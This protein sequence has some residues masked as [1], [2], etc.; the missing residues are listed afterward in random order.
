M[1]HL[2]GGQQGGG[3]WGFV[4]GGM[5]GISAA[6]ARS[7]ARFGMQIATQAPVAEVLVSAGRAQDVR[8]VDGREFRAGVVACNAAATT[9]FR[10]LVARRHLPAEL[11]R[12]IDTFRTFSTVFKM[13]IAAHEPP[14]Y[15]AFDAAREQFG[16]PTYVHIR[17]DL[18]YLERAH[19]DAKY[20]WYPR[21]PIPT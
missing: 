21:R 6:I 16:Y 17:P 13:N 7:G 12:E 1:H 19:A 18:E 3:G 14:R 10:R 4:R 2:M 11:L 15:R 9:L 8:T 20:G 5:G